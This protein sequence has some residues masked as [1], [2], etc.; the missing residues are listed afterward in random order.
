MKSRFKLVTQFDVEEYRCGLKSGDKLILLKDLVVKNHKGAPTGAVHKAGS[1]WVVLNGSSHDPGTI[2][3]RQPDG[4]LHFWDDSPS[5][6][7][8]FKRAT[9]E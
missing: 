6:F 2:R 3:L 9:T 5:I 4:K 8:F 7:D 1:T